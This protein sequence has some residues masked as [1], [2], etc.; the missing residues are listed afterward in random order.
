[1]FDKEIELHIKGIII[2]WDKIDGRSYLRDIDSI[3]GISDL[4]FHKPITFFVGENVYRQP[5]TDI[6]EIT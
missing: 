3:A 4:R 2:D 1:M 6:K 5:R